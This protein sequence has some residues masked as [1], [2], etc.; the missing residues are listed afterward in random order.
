MILVG[1]QRGGARDLA[2]HLMK[3]E[4]EHIEL[5]EL[6]GFCANNLMD[7]L[8][9]AYAVSQ[10]TRCRK[11]L[12]SL[13]LNPPPGEAVS[14][15]DFEAAIEKA[16]DRLG[17]NGQPRAIVFHEKEG[18]RHAHAV[19]SRIDTAEMKAVQLSYDRRRLMALSRELFI[20][21]DWRMPE[22]L[23][24]EGS[25]DPRNFTLA[26]WQQ[27]KRIGKDPRAAKAA[28]Q[29]AWAISDSRSAF[30]LALEERGFRLARGDRRGFVAVDVHGEVYSIPRM[31]GIKTKAARERLGNE[32][33]LVS[34][35]E[36]KAQMAREMLPAF[37]RMAAEMKAQGRQARRDYER[38]RLGMAERQRAERLALHEAIEKRRIEE[39][40]Q[41]QSR[42][43]KGLQG[44]WDRLRG[45][46]GRVQ[47]RNER[48]AEAAQI[49]DRRQRD[50]LIQRHLRERRHLV[51]FRLRERRDFERSR[52]ELDRDAQ[53]RSRRARIRREPER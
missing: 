34:V 13:S 10:G 39:S 28:I 37:A 6:R 48:E 47:R 53:E 19:W 1:S 5:H 22:G 31:A 7:A 27:A 11:F 40:R 41:R 43:R 17:L 16:E 29:D 3:D 8:S 15:A 14:T 20:E 21:K 12:Y 4:N 46:Y 18:R 52:K 26:E 9:E 51:V 36:A 23:A 42:F 32:S 50:E 24:R 44:L 2:R 45:E 38:R 30:T 35:D 33:E 49:R 25:S